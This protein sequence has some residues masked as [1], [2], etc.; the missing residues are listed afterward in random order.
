MDAFLT[1]R[2]PSLPSN[3]GGFLA[4]EHSYLSLIAM[5]LSPQRCCYHQL[6]AGVIDPLKVLQWLGER[7][8]ENTRCFNK[9]HVFVHFF[10]Y[11]ANIRGSEENKS[12]FSLGVLEWRIATDMIH[13]LIFFCN[14]I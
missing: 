5:K 7:E 13:V 10:L 9:L 1:D 6:F 14:F 4:P 2:K 11:V 8:A 12:Q 3:A